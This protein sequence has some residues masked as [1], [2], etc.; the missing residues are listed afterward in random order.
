[1]TDAPGWPGIPP[2][3]TS[4]AKSGV[5]TA[6]SSVSRVWFTLSHGI[7]DEIYYPRVDQAC[8]RDFGFIVT[9]GSDFFAEEK[10]DCTSNIARLEDGVPAFRLINT[11]KGGRFRIVKDVLTDQWADV[12]TQRVRLEV[13]DG[14][15]LRLF[16]LLAPHLVNGGAHNTAWIGEYQGPSVPVRRGRRH[17]A[18]AR[19]L[20][21]I[22]RLFRGLCRCFGWLAN[23]A[24]ERPTQ[25]PIR[26]RR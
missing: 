23:P 13:L 9:D 20:A 10:R 1:M 22:P 19:L 8:T 25:G 26:T 24:A 2:R 6:I 18:F 14:S 12:V 16:A 7:L 4:S 11:H 21:S 17:D 3:W 5:G 15:S